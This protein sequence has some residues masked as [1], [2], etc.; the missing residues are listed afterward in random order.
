MV[1]HTCNSN[2]W[3]VETGDS[4]VQGHLQIH[5][6]LETSLSHMKF[7]TGLGMSPG[8]ER[9][10]L[11]CMKSWVVSEKA[12]TEVPSTERELGSLC[13]HHQFSEHREEV[14]LTIVSM[15]Q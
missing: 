12:A 15:L 3:Q 8:W 5:R 4:E 10:C 14:N 9:A 6:K 7:Q 11:V 1:E 2:S 13:G